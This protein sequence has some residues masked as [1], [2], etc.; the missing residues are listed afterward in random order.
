MK[1]NTCSQNKPC[2]TLIIVIFQ[3]HVYFEQVLKT[4]V[5]IKDIKSLFTECVR[6]RIIFIQ[7]KI[8]MKSLKKDYKIH[9]VL[10]C[11]VWIVIRNVSQNYFSGLINMH[12]YTKQRKRARRIDFVFGKWNH[13]SNRKLLL[14]RE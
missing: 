9:A 10:S 3:Q 14:L 7:R 11:C 5:F 12:E 4:L 2:Y 1:K 6:E 8:A 13:C